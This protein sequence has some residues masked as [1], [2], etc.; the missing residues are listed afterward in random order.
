MMEDDDYATWLE[1]PAYRMRIDSVLTTD[2]AWR[3][4]AGQ[5][6]AKLKILYILR[7]TCMH[8]TMSINTTRKELMM[9]MIRLRARHVMCSSFSD[10]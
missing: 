10:H 1:K 3:R 8:M 5:V 2:E 7:W 9:M 4:P 6:G